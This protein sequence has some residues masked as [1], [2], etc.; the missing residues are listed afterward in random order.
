[1]STPA[2]PT[3]PTGNVVTYVRVSDRRAE[4]IIEI[5]P[6][7]AVYYRA[8]TYLGLLPARLISELKPLLQRGEEAGSP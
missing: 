6:H 5:A 3:I 1:M 8:A 4:T 2:S 7:Q